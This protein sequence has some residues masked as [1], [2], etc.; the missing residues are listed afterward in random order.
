M[1]P[2]LARIVHVVHAAEAGAEPDA[3]QLVVAL[4]VADF[5]RGVEIQVLDPD[6]LGPE[7]DAPPPLLVQ[8]LLEPEGA[9][10]PCSRRSF[11]GTA[12]S[13]GRGC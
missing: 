3:E 12:P 11:R 13:S 10:E 6:V 2:P 7:A 9:L 8:A 5:L 1:L 4:D